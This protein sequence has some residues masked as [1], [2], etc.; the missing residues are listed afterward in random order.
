[1]QKDKFLR[2]NQFFPVTSTNVGI[3]PKNFLTFSFNLSAIPSASS[4]FLNLNQEHFSKRNL[5][6][7]FLI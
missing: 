3:S 5:Y 2:K 6:L 7:Y 1:M 4:K